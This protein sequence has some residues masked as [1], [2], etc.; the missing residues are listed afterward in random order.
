MGTSELAQILSIVTMS[1][2]IVTALGRWLVVIPLKRLIEEHTK[3]IQPNANG[4]RSLPDVAK[5][6]AEIKVA[7]ESLAHQIDRVESR[8]DTHIEQH[9]EGKA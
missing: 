3:P 4:G 2:G 8:L 7:V 6:T 1:I 5:T 9:V